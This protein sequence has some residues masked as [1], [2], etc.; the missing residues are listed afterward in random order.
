MIINLSF[1]YDLRKYSFNCRIVDVWNS[2]PQHVVEASNTN[3]FK[4]RFQILVSSIV[5]I[6]GKLTYPGLE[7]DQK[8]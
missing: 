8:M 1:H 3:I 5:N 7:V 2:L 6:S 4:T